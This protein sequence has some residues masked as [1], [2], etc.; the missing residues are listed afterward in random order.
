MIHELLSRL[1]A[2]G[3]ERKRWYRFDLDSAAVLLMWSATFRQ[4][5]VS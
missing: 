3:H 4:P 2:E 5:F 1:L